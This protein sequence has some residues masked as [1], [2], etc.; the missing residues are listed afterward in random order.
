[1]PPPITGKEVVELF[2]KSELAKSVE[3]DEATLARVRQLAANAS[4]ADTLQPLV[5]GG[6][7]TRWQADQLLE[8]KYKRFHLGKFLILEKLASATDDF[9]RGRHPRMRRSVLLR[10]NRYHVP[11]PMPEE[12]FE[13]CGDSSTITPVEHPNLVRSIDCDEDEGVAFHVLEPLEGKQLPLVL[14]QVGGRLPLGEACGCAIQIARGLHALHERK[15]VHE[16][17]MPSNVFV[18]DDGTVKILNHTFATR[19]DFWFIRYTLASREPLDATFAA[20]EQSEDSLDVAWDKFWK[21]NRPN[22][23]KAPE[24]AAESASVDG[25]CD[26]YSLGLVLSHM[27]HMSRMS[28]QPREASSEPNLLHRLVARWRGGSQKQ[29]VHEQTPSALASVLTK[30][31]AKKPEDRYQSMLEVIE[32]LRPFVVSASLGTCPPMAAA[33]LSQLAP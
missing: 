17:I 26:C 11:D 3:S 21:K 18:C 15:R 22:A 32:A 16:R 20:P 9:F 5:Q 19:S 14:T 29:T 2:L 24:Q 23:A 7:L 1:M 6:Y 33:A 13:F 31:T 25:R 27:S 28:D 4:P 8:G 12:R 10:V 30:M